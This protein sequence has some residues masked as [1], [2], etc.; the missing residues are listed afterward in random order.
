L[1]VWYWESYYKKCKDIIRLRDKKNFKALITN[2]NR[3]E[4]YFKY[5]GITGFNNK[6]IW[7][8]RN[9][10]FSKD[11]L[12]GS[13]LYLKYSYIINLSEKDCFNSNLLWEYDSEGH[14][15]NI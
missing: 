15:Q 8:E 3:I 6:V 7:M 10:N 14:K 5:S 13:L 12:I 11:S 2:L 4:I 9:F 1:F